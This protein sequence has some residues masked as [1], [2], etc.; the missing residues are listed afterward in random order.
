[1]A[2]RHRQTTI[3]R[4]SPPRIKGSSGSTPSSALELPRVVLFEAARSIFVGAAVGAAVKVGA[5]VGTA[6]GCGVGGAGVGAA[7]GAKVTKGRPMPAV[8]ACEIS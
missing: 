1:M 2:F 8:I 7:V 3:I 5:A 4:K 6:V